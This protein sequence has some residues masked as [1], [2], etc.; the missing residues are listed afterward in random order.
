MSCYINW[1]YQAF[2]AL[3]HPE[4]GTIMLLKMTV[5]IYQSTHSHIPED[6]NLHQ[7]QRV[8]LKFHKALFLHP[9]PVLSTQ[10][11]LTQYL[12]YKLL[13]SWN[14]TWY[15]PLY[16]LPNVPPTTVCHWEKSL[17]TELAIFSTCHSLLL[18][19]LTPHLIHHH[20]DCFPSSFMALY[21]YLS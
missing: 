5:T 17:E 21:S 19:I 11:T 10:H 12:A 3:L 9:I 1:Y 20:P 15:L 16:F 8:N 13:P 2:L 7:H 18:I 14:S 6:I 4:D